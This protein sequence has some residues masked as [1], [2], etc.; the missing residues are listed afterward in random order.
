MQVITADVQACKSVVHVIDSVL[1]PVKVPA[2]APLPKPTLK[3]Q[4]RPYL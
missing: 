2:A 1:L 4:L 3:E